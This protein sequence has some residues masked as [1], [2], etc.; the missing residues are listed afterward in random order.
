VPN[1]RAANSLDSYWLLT[2]QNY[3]APRGVRSFSGHGWLIERPLSAHSHP[4][5]GMHNYAKTAFSA[6]R[7]TRRADSKGQNTDNRLG[8]T[9]GRYVTL[10]I[11][12]SVQ[13]PQV[14]PD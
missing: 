14:V 10:R 9:S 6:W 1:I 2:S 7:Q 8:A 5:P 3:Q 13:I 11:R 4:A 12:A